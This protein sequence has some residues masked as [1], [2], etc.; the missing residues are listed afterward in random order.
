MPARPGW[1]EGPKAWDRETRALGTDEFGFPRES[2]SQP[3][4]NVW[5][6]GHKR[7]KSGS[8]QGRRNKRKHETPEQEE[9]ELEARIAAHSAKFEHLRAK[10]V[11]LLVEYGWEIDPS[12]K[13]RLY[14]LLEIRKDGFLLFVETSGFQRLYNHL[15]R[16][17]E[18][19]G[20]IDWTDPKH[21]PLPLPY[22]LTQWIEEQTMA[23]TDSQ[24]QQFMKE[25]RTMHAE[26]MAA[27]ADKPAPTV[28]GKPAAEPKTA[29]GR[30]KERWDSL[31][32][33]GVMLG[34]GALGLSF[35]G[36]SI[37]EAVAPIH[38]TLNGPQGHP[39]QGLIMSVRSMSGYSDANGNHVK[40]SLGEINEKL[41]E[42]LDEKNKRQPQQQE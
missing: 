6:Q 7:K 33:I 31:V 32:V 26:L 5:S 39:E 11:K 16:D 34:A 38:Q 23:M 21:G 1:P 30:I 37:S 17:P 25:Q 4:R 35:L 2:Q 28:A 19:W 9:R 15:L 40:G 20:Y 18:A 3:P 42:L 10:I 24:F 13:D 8:G 12:P 36:T 29:W 14:G 41:D 27:L 22:H